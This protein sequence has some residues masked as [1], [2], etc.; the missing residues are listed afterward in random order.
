M[1]DYENLKDDIK[2]IKDTVKDIFKVLNG[3]G[4]DGL[5]TKTA[6]NRSSIRRLWWVVGIAS[7]GF[8]GCVGFLFVKALGG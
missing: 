2:E 3:N 6:L 4:S 8:V 1:N 7:T 5:V